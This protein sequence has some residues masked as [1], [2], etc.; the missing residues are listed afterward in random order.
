[1]PAEVFAHLAQLDPGD[2]VARRQL[3]LH[4]NAL[5]EQ[6]RSPGEA[7]DEFTAVADREIPGYD[8]AALRLP[9]RVLVTG[10]TGCVG[11]AVLRLLAEHGVERMVSVARRPVPPGRRLPGVVY[12]QADVRH[13]A[14]L[15]SLFLQERPELVIHTAGQRQPALA[16]QLVAETISS[17]VFGTMTV[18]AAAG[19][20]RVPRVVHCSTGKALRFFASDV[21]AATKK[22]SE[23]LLATA[24]DHWGVR[25]SGTRFTHVVDNSVVYRRLLDWAAAGAPVRI[26]H[27]DIAFYAQSARE[28][29][30]LLVVA[31]QEV[32]AAGASVAAIS[33]LGWPHTLLDVALDVIDRAGTGA[34]VYISG[35]E[36]GYEEAAYPGTFDPRQT[37]ASTPL[38]NVLE[39][40]AVLPEA[41]LGP[42][43]EHTPLPWSVDEQLDCQLM[44]LQSALRRGAAED[45]LREEL[46]HA[47]AALLRA[48]F[49]T[50]PSTGLAAVAAL[51]GDGPFDTWEHRLVDRHL[52]SALEGR[53]RRRRFPGAERF[54]ESV[55]HRSGGAVAYAV[56]EG[57]AI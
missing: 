2:P 40:A 24:N 7:L 34:P 16:E 36:K 51:A 42:A 30:Q 23:Y 10:G 41:P 26:H 43:V 19:E 27:P 35:Y 22:L 20:A 3:R 53:R 37:A 12:R 49:A 29:A 8:A 14:A 39:A 5:L 57:S 9:S 50:A 46:L 55:P 56:T 33:N 21:Y 13:R 45:V 54:D 11:T 15:R 28:A 32:P 18:L 47:S 1:M 31:A 52:R 25:C 38:F 44:S 17:N 6:R 48:T 4:T